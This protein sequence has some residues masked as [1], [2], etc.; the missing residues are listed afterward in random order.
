LRASIEVREARSPFV[1]LRSEYMPD[2]GGPGTHRGGAANIHDVR[3]ANSAWHRLQQFHVR[4]AAG[5]GGVMGGRVGTLGAA[6]CWDG[7]TTELGRSGGHIPLALDHPA[8]LQATPISGVFD[9]VTHQADPSGDFVPPATHTA[10]AGSII[11]LLTNGSGGWGDPLERDVA[12]VLADVRDEYVTVDG[13][14]RD[15]GVVVLGDP[16]TDPEGLEVD[17]AATARLRA[18]LRAKQSR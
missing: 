2:S 6:W 14:A 8:Y 5:T 4:S 11:R 16:C 10:S 7:E 3:W 17:A 9:P 13:A 12:R 18:E 1:V 15:Y